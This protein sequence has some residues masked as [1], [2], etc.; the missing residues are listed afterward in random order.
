MSIR[1]SPV[2][3]ENISE[4]MITEPDS[5]TSAKE[6]KRRSVFKK[7]STCSAVKM[8]PLVKEDNLDDI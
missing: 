2:V 7:N 3:T 8:F 6:V 4:R 1:G 5:P